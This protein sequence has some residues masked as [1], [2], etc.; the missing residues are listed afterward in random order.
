[1][2]WPVM[3]PVCRHG[4]TVDGQPLDLAALA[5]LTSLSYPEPLAAAALKQAS[6]RT[7]TPLSA[8]TDILASSLLDVNIYL[9]A[10]G[11]CQYRLQ[12]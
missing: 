11:L 10:K 2:C 3:A 7:T 9:D 6:L 1:M 4:P 5:Q 12:G 8:H